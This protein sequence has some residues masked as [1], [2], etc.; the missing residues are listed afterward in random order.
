MKKKKYNRPFVEV[1]TLETSNGMMAGS[2]GGGNGGTTVSPDGSEETNPVNP[3]SMKRT[4]GS[5]AWEDNSEIM[6]DDMGFKA[7]D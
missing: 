4:S 7:Y 2:P 5:S 6:D 1:L 3:R